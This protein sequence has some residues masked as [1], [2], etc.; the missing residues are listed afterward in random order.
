MSTAT[1]TAQPF[2]A[3]LSSKDGGGGERLCNPCLK[4]NTQFLQYGDDGRIAWHMGKLRHKDLAQLRSCAWAS[5]PCPF[6][7]L[8]WASIEDR[9]PPEHVRM[10]VDSWRRSRDRLFL[11]MQRVFKDFHFDDGRHNFSLRRVTKHHDTYLAPDL[12][13]VELRFRSVCQLH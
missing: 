5:V 8:L 12:A 1:P 4:I 2:A 7:R 13:G 9:M 10:L 3:Y 6:C 11:V